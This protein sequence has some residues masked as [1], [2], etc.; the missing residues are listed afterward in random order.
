LQALV[1]TSYAF[2]VILLTF[3]SGYCGDSI[4]DDAAGE[5]CD[6]G[7]ELNGVSICELFSTISFSFTDTFS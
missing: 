5:T 2:A 4:I 3:Y 7:Y 6:N 1:R